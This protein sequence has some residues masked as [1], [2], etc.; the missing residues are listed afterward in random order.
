MT[1]RVVKLLQTLGL[2][3]ALLLLAL[4]LRKAWGELAN[5]GLSVRWDRAA[6]GVAIG[7]VGYLASVLVWQR[8]LD[9][10]GARTRFVQFFPICVLA[11]LG[12]YL[13][14]KVWQVVGMVVLGREMGVSVGVSA[15]SSILFLGFYVSGGAMLGLVLFPGEYLPVW[16]RLAAWLIACAPTALLLVPDAWAAIAR[17]APRR[18]SLESAPRISRMLVGE[19]MVFQTGTWCLHGLAF[20]VFAS[21]LG[22]L[23]WRRFPLVCGSY[24]LAY[25]TGLLAVFAPGGIGVREGALG[26]LLAEGDLVGVPVHVTAVSSRIFFVAYEL[27]V[28]LAAIGVRWHTTHSTPSQLDGPPRDL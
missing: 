28:V 24:V 3:A 8:L 2:C 1:Q 16:A 4:T 5:S 10:L 13:P 9:R 15:A 25:I 23:E 19:Q 20:F 22:E 17:R 21:A 14:G 7:S 12:R 27:I 6:L 11:N 18:L 26:F